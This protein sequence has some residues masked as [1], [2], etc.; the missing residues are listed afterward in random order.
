[1]DPLDRASAHCHR[2]ARAPKG[3]RSRVRPCI[4]R[5]EPASSLRGEPHPTKMCRRQSPGSN[6]EG[7]WPGG[8]LCIVNVIVWWGGMPGTIDNQSRRSNTIRTLSVMIRILLCTPRLLQYYVQALPYLLY[9]VS[10]IVH[11]YIQHTN[12]GGF[13]MSKA[14]ETAPC[15]ALL[16]LSGAFSG[17]AP[18]CVP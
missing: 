12:T 14:C 5:V 11:T 17:P 10:L 18:P 8:S 6:R 4:Q 2:Q 13:C 16:F 15:C 1:M 9:L 3:K 7:W